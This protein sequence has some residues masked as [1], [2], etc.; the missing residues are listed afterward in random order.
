VDLFLISDGPG[1]LAA[2]FFS[3]TLVAP[4]V[5]GLTLAQLQK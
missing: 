5:L 3:I 2:A 4:L 1:I